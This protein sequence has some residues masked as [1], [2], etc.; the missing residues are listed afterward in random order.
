MVRKAPAKW[1]K[2]IPAAIENER[3]SREILAK[4]P[5]ISP[6]KIKKGSYICVRVQDS[7][8][9]RLC[10]VSRSYRRKD[11]LVTLLTKEGAEESVT[12][13]SNDS[14]WKALHHDLEKPLIEWNI[15]VNNSENVPSWKEKIALT[16][17]KKKVMPILEKYETVQ[18]SKKRHRESSDRD[19]NPPKRRRSS[20]IRLENTSLDLTIS[21]EVHSCV[22]RW[23][24]DDAPHFAFGTL[25]VGYNM[26]GLFFAWEEISLHSKK[27]FSFSLK[28]LNPNKAKPKSET[29]TISLIGDSHIGRSNCELTL[30]VSRVRHTLTLQGKLKIQAHNRKKFSKAV[31]FTAVKVQS[32]EDCL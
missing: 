14:N 2:L 27:V 32:L 11:G 31:K 3:V 9:W 19:S 13:R 16:Q 20:S 8:S 7:N 30:Q 23:D 28:G 4:I 5:N 22:G 17:F 26:T 1:D 18:N 12:L 29:A 10:L 6:R 24:I 15:G 21:T 25:V